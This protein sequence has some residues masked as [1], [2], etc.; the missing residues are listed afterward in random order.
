MI[1]TASSHQHASIWMQG[2]HTPLRVWPIFQ[3]YLTDRLST[4]QYRSL[5][6]TKQNRRR[7]DNIR[8]RTTTTA[9]PQPT[10]PNRAR[11]TYRFLYLLPP[12]YLDDTTNNNNDPRPSQHKRVSAQIEKRQTEKRRNQMQLKLAHQHRRSINTRLYSGKSPRD[13]IVADDAVCIVQSKA[14]VRSI[15]P[16]DATIF[17]P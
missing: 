13:G 7:S 3:R 1:S 14:R 8:R 11:I 16:T 6:A 10:K 5:H 9:P 4:L 17:L 12:S 15:D 2:G